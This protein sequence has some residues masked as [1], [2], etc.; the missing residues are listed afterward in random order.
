M[1]PPLLNVV[2][3][4]KDY[5]HTPVFDDVDLTIDAGETVGLS[6]KSG[7]GKSTLGR[8]ILR[9]EEPTAGEVYYNG[10]DLLKMGKKDLNLVRP[11]LQMIFQHPETSFNP[12]MA[13]GFGIAEP[14]SY[15]TGTRPEEVL[16]G[17]ADLLRRV[18]L[19][20]DQLDRFPHQLSGGELQRA[21]LARVFS[22]QPKLVIADEPTSMLDVS[23]QA[24]VLGLMKTLQ[25]ETGV[26]YLL[27]SHD[28]EVLGAVCDRVAYMRNGTVEKADAG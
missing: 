12:R 15:R 13:V 26:S 1:P 22:L 8:C 10:A 18:G 17:L 19:R 20:R 24:Q 9:L 16:N 21:M 3:L 2:G 11:D 25:E 5:G 27:I 28:L 23:V 6:G 7:S 4:R 14:L